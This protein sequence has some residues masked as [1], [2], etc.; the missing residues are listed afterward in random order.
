MSAQTRDCCR[1][2]EVWRDCPGFE[3]RYQVSN[4]GRV[5]ALAREIPHSLGGVA[6]RRERIFAIDQNRRYRLVTFTDGEG[7]QSSHNVHRLV[8]LTFV[9]PRPAGSQINHIDWDTHHNCVENLEYCEPIENVRH[10]RA[11]KYS[12]RLIETIRSMRARG[13]TP[14]AI[15]EETG[16]SRKYVSEITGRRAR[17]R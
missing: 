4:R 6:L 3:G 1:R 5:K 7:R 2:R 13:I 16:V 11:T 15:S 17:A 9:G 10:S 8:A 12:A 14:R